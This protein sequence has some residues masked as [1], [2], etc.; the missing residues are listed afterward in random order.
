MIEIHPQNPQARLVREVADMI[1]SGG[2][3]AY[4]TDSSYAFGWAMG[5]KSAQERIRRLKHLDKHHHFTLVCEGLSELASYARVDN[6]AY[7][8]LRALT[9]GPYTFILPAT[10]QVPNRLQ[11]PK[12]KTI[13]IRVPANPIA[14][15]LLRELPE[16]LL[17]TT[18]QLPEQDEPMNEPW[19]IRELLDHE[20]AAVVDGGPCALD[21]TSVVDLT[22]PVP[23][24]ARVGLGDVSHLETA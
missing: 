23:V 22:G 8:L 4:P 10:R 21:S 20:L 24:V 9:P 7:R 14:L 11:H 15:A 18:L 13:G 1:E 17:S 5:N 19:E 6:Q 3:V 16:P 12:R 2:I